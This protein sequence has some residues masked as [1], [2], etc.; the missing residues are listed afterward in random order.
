MLYH[1]ASL[2]LA[3]GSNLHML[4]DSDVLACFDGYPIL[5][6]GAVTAYYNIVVRLLRT[7]T[8][9]CGNMYCF[10]AAS[11]CFNYI[12]TWIITCMHSSM[13]HGVLMFS[14]ASHTGWGRISF[15]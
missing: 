1:N 4:A 13:L 6:N 7:C 2:R 8:I 9:P 14:I 3:K 12:A 10:S 11:Q 15:S 5:L